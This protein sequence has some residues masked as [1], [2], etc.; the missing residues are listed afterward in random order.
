MASSSDKLE[1]SARLV[2]KVLHS[3][4]SIKIGRKSS[5]GVMVKSCYVSG[6]HCKIDVTKSDSSASGEK[7]DSL[8]FFVSDLSSN[9]TWF[10][11]G[12]LKAGK[13]G[14]KNAE[15]LGKVRKEFFP[16][17]RILLLAPGHAECKM[18]CFAV[19]EKGSEYILEQLPATFEWN[20]SPATKSSKG[21][22]DQKEAESA[23]V[24]RKRSASASASG[25]EVTKKHCGST[26]L[27][28]R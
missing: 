25:D 2:S 27:E 12:P 3:G 4:D 18:Y 23:V 28:V 19:K 20:K 14:C 21:G 5:C 16:G 8:R 6:T 15:K 9:G 1:A 26:T 24:G 7:S 10:L 11:K 17:D 22:L 13:N